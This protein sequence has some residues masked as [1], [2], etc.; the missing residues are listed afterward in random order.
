[1]LELSWEACPYCWEAFPCY[2]EACPCRWEA[3]GQA[4]HQQVSLVWEACLACWVAVH[5]SVSLKV[6]TGN[7]EKFSPDQVHSF[8]VQV[9]SVLG[10]PLVG[11]ALDLGVPFDDQEVPWVVP[12]D[13]LA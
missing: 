2:W 4:F 5:W 7:W 8:E 11:L 6:L 9:H 1:M 12:G 13:L 10:H 3:W